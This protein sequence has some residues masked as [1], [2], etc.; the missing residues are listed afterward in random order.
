MEITTSIH[1]GGDNDGNRTYNI[2]YHRHCIGTLHS[3][4]LQE[5]VLLVMLSPIILTHKCFSA[6]Q[7]KLF[8]GRA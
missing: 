4:I 5:I 2:T 8:Q 7:N 6:V 3:G 1:R